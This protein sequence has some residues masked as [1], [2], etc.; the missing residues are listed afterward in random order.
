MAQA[1][2]LAVCWGDTVP[3]LCG[4][5]LRVCMLVF[6]PSEEGGGSLDAYVTEHSHPS[7]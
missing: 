3:A 2:H 5:V 7:D 6:R 1:V 4:D